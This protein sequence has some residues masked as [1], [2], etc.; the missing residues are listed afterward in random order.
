MLHA[1]RQAIEFTGAR[2]TAEFVQES[3]AR[4]AVE[5]AIGIIGEAASAIT[6]ALRERHPELPWRRIIGMRNVLAHRYAEVDF[7]LMHSVVKD[8]LPALIL[9]LEALLAGG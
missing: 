3:M 2:S 4:M 6:P 1:A 9:T 5:R 8:D 7:A